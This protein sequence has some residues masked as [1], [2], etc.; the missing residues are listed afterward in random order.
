M[1]I[2]KLIAENVKKLSVVEITP[3][4]NL[5]QI[6]GKNGQGKS[7]VL[8]AIWWALA[9]Q[10]NIQAAPIRKGETE[11]RIVLDLGEITVRR[12]FKQR[13]VKDG[14]GN[15]QPDDGYT[16]AIV[17]ENADGSRFP[18]P[19]RMLD[20]LLGAL[21]FDPLAFA[22]APPKMQFE[23]LKQFVPGIDFAAI[24]KANAQD[25]DARTDF[26]RR[27]KEARAQAAGIS[28]PKD[29]PADAIDEAALVQQLD[30]AGRHNSDI[31]ERSGRRE[32]AVEQAQL[33]RDEAN[34]HRQT[35]RQ[36]RQQADEHDGHAKDSDAKAAEIDK[37]LADAPALPQ[38]IDTTVIRENIAKARW[39]NALI[40]KRTQKAELESLAEKLAEKAGALTA[41]MEKRENDKRASI[42]AAKL[43]IPN[44][45]F[46]D[47]VILMNG[48]PF[49]QASDAEKLRASIAI[50]MA[51]NPKLRVIRVRDGSL[52]DDDGLKLL[53]EM[54]D[55][56]DC[57]VWIERVDSSGKIGFVLE[58]GHLKAASEPVAD[59][60][61]E[62]VKRGKRAPAE[63]EN[64]L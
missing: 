49:E 28:V 48:V 30:D 54:A 20:G 34:R 29:T 7:S 12:T 40:A 60:P 57:Q 19:Q 46:G 22:N 51:S 43:P 52:L 50:A 13:T 56:A 24:E 38:P 25:Y 36:L 15:E 14:D 16:T 41:A 62:K 2:A 23:A 1:K 8:D 61:A 17:V 33:C 64:I 18:S 4:G 39:T 55:R 11:A 44:V 27:A 5:V 21:S 26:N 32:R 10:T 9:G 45:E 3:D 58:D 37:K 47:G 59:K 6:T 35:A 42:G 31:V 53:A 63:Q